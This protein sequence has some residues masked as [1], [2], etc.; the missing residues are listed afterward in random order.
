MSLGSNAS[1]VYS[2]MLGGKSVLKVSGST[3]NIVLT[4]NSTV[5]SDIA[6]SSHAND[7]ILGGTGETVTVD[8]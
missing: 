7:V 6:D 5:N 2:G 4:A 3:A 1:L 8:V